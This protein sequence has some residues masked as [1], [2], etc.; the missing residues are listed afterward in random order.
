MSHKGFWRF[1]Y[2][3]HFP[4]S[5]SYKTWSCPTE[6]FYTRCSQGQRLPTWDEIPHSRILAWHR[7]VRSSEETPR[8]KRRWMGCFH[9]PNSSHHNDALRVH[10]TG[11]QGCPPCLQSTACVVSRTTL[12]TLPQIQCHLMQP[13][14]LP[15]CCL[16]PINSD[17][18]STS[19]STL[20]PQSE[21]RRLFLN[22]L[23]SALLS[24]VSSNSTCLSHIAPH[25]GKKKHLTQRAFFIDIIILLWFD[26]LAHSFISSTQKVLNKPSICQALS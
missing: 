13:R 14:K 18:C 26:S 22:C 5:F 19:C 9:W 15:I 10:W 24:L 23:L 7:T 6:N 8:T 17:Q 12:L 3:L 21:T 20:S 16:S 1:T 2:T 25:P 4:I 11:T